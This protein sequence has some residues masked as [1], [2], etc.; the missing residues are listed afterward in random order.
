MTARKL[1]ENQSHW[2]LFGL[3]IYH[4]Q[5]FSMDLQKSLNEDITKQYDSKAYYEEENPEFGRNFRKLSVYAD[6]Q[7]THVLQAKTNAM[8]GITHYEELETRVREHAVNYLRSLTNFPH[9]HLLDKMWRAFSWWSCFDQKDSYDWHNHS[10]FML[11]CTYYVQNEER[12]TPIAFRNPI[13]NLIEAW[14]PGKMHG[15][16]IDTVIKPKT[17]DL[18]IWPG[19]LEHYV[20]NKNVWSNEES[21]ADNQEYNRGGNFNR[22]IASEEPKGYFN[23]ERDDEINITTTNKSKD[24]RKSITIN[25]M[26]PDEQFGYIASKALENYENH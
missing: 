12:H 9:E 14:L 5:N 19:W 23:N 17:G 1:E 21:K 16:D 7:G 24:S 10:Q 26:K 2:N 18:I 11:I 6:P 15:I 3:P 4:I 20:F 8:E 22:A 25:Y 13:G